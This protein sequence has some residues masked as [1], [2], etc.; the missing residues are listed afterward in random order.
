MKPSMV[1]GKLPDRRKVLF[2]DGEDKENEDDEGH[3]NDPSL[4][5][6]GRSVLVVNR[7]EDSDETHNQ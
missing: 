3:A 6:T 2:D 4:K 7:E 5:S 1:G